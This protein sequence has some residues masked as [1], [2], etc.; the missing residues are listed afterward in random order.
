MARDLTFILS[1]PPLTLT[2]AVYFIERGLA[3]AGYKHGPT[4]SRI[5]LSDMP[6][7]SAHTEVD[8]S[9]DASQQG[10]IAGWLA[11]VMEFFSDT[12]T[13]DIS[14]AQW[15]QRYTNIYIDAN[16]NILW[17]KPRVDHFNIFISTVVDIARS[18]RALGGVGG[19]MFDLNKITPNMLPTAIMNNVA[20]PGFPSEM[21][22]IDA[23][24]MTENAVHATA[25]STFE[26]ETH[27]GYWLLLAKDFVR[28][29]ETDQL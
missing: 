7:L 15:D 10:G 22:L 16:A 24:V 3:K 26:I 5:D 12:S 20:N 17:R 18:V 1:T 27:D 19:L 4:I 14:V 29:L 11:L 8:V 6:G 28:L 25:G 13:I 21:G 9:F 2:D 23:S